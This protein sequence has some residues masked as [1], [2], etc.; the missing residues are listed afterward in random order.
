MAQE[1]I[2]YLGIPI[3]PL[4]KSLIPI[5]EPNLAALPHSQDYTHLGLEISMQNLIAGLTQVEPE[6]IQLSDP[7]KEI[8]ADYALACHPLAKSLR[9]NPVEIANSIADQI[10]LGLRPDLIERVSAQDGFINF[11]ID[12]NLYGEKVLQEIETG[13]DSYGAQNIGEGKKVV[14]DCSAP[15]IAKYMSV[16]HLRSTVIGESLHRI[17]QTLG[18]TAIRDN[19]LGDWGTQFGMLGYAYEKWRDEI[20]EFE[21]GG[22]SIKGFY[23]LYVRIHEEV[24]QEEEEHPDN[25]SSLRKA[26]KGWFQRLENGDPA[27]R[28]LFNWAWGA[29]IK[30]FQRVYDLLGV[31]FEYTLGESFYVD[32]GMI[33]NVVNALKQNGVAKT[34]EKGAV[35]IPIEE[36]KLK[37]LIIQKSD[38]TSLYAT[39]EIAAL[40]CRIAWFNPASILYVVGADQKGYFQQVFAAANKITAGKGPDL[41]H[42]YFGMVSLP[43]G[44]MSTR[45]G[46]L[47]F[48]E[49]MLNE[50]VSR[51]KQR[52]QETN[53]N[54]SET[55]MVEVARQVGIGA[56][57]YFDLGQSR[58][59]DILFNWDHA[60]SLESNSAPYIQYTNARTH[61]IL[62]RAEEK[63]ITIDFDQKVVFSLPEEQMLIKQ[64]AKFPDTI[65]RAQD[66]NQPS[67]IAEHLLS[68]ATLFNQ[69]YQKTNVINEQDPVKRNT[70]LRLI[71]AVSQVM[72]RGLYLLGIEA[73]NRM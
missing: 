27:A 39:R 35:V 18:Y 22:D 55:E 33:P 25:E 10:N 52:I 21:E 2:Q 60:L 40:V 70:R 7:P 30:E 67:V 13:R 8:A 47:V 14:I 50:G 53:R 49:D 15:N 62:E 24:E 3:P 59:R 43:E 46:R 72:K 12:N 17:Y 66:I 71:T 44:K 26:G 61:S 69:F 42:I 37:P 19:H 68:V 23:K 73:P 5:V 28:R 38:G 58:E 20:P 54:F 16:G 29:S 1:V 45:R 36:T 4:P 31:E 51:A 63:G 41:K 65:R 34:D 9:I 32:Q 6:S 56:A 64:L 57:I 48:L 11:F